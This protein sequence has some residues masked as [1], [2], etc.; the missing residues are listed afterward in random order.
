MKELAGQQQ[1]AEP[2][3]EGGGLKEKS[4]KEQMMEKLIKV[5]DGEDVVRERLRRERSR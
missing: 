1:L 4:V 2:V 3:R 5:E